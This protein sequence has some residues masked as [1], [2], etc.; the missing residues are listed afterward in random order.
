MPTATTHE[1]GLYWRDGPGVALDPSEGGAHWSVCDYR[2]EDWRLRWPHCSCGL[3]AAKC[4]AL[5]A[6]EINYLEDV[7]VTKWTDD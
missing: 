4:P 3:Y 1:R 7:K 6:K 2:A 5:T